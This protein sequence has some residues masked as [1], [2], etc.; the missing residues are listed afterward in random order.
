MKSSKFVEFLGENLISYE[1]KSFGR[2]EYIY[3][4]DNVEPNWMV[5]S[6]DKIDFS[7][8]RLRN[9]IYQAVKLEQ[10]GTKWNQQISQLFSYRIRCAIWRIRCLYAN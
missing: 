2:N 1:A 4:L 8:Y 3:L 7:V 6:K 9:Q 10:I 5:L